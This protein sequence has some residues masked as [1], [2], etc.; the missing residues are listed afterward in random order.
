MKK[1]SF[2]YGIYQM[3]TIERI[4]VTNILEVKKMRQ[5]LN[6]HKELLEL[7]DC[8]IKI[9]NERLNNEHLTK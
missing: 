5:V 7:F 3:P 8:M 9:I 1:I 4:D 2:I 6:D